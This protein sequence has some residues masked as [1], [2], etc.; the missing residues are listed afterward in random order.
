MDG[1]INLTVVIIS[2]CTHLVRASPQYA[3]VVGS[4]SGQGTYKKAT[5]KCISGTTN[6]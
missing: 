1:L 4:I 3:M 5:N 2:Q 6:Q